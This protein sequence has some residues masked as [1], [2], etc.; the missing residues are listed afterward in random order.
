M[1]QRLLLA[2][3]AVLVIGAVAIGAVGATRGNW[4]TGSPG[5]GMMSGGPA[6][7]GM[8]GG[9]GPGGMGVYG[10]GM[11]GGYYTQVPAGAQTISIDQ[12]QQ[13]VERYLVQY[14]GSDLQVDELIEFQDNFYAIVKE[15]S[16][17]NGAFELLVDRVSGAVGLEPG[18]N[19]MW[20]TKYGM[21][22]GGMMGLG[23]PSGTLTVSKDRAGKIAQSWLD[24]N[25]NGAKI[26]EPDT[27]Y[28]YYTV[29]FTVGGKV[30]GMLSVNGYSGTV[31][32]HTW[33]G[34]FIQEKQVNS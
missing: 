21:M 19:M 32:Y 29:H 9:F 5:V 2:V 4:F 23:R 20:T 28:G 10:G 24:A 13:S 22:A 18:P 26:E 6:R 27:F 25:Q 1:G 33:H 16:T 15:K 17:G 3:G 8:M 7:G 34:A 14:G 12:A 30:A 11:M 31:W